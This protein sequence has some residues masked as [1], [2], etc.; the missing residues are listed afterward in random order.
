MAGSQ[1]V[2]KSHL[3]PLRKCPWAWDPAQPM[4]GIKEASGHFRESNFNDI[5]ARTLRKAGLTHHRGMLYCLIE[6]RVAGL[7]MLPAVPLGVVGMVWASKA[8]LLQIAV[9]KCHG[10]I[11]DALKTASCVRTHISGPSKYNP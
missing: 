6:V 10:G 3:E 9:D 2:F 8:L 7:M 11:P 5:A 1:Q 4:A